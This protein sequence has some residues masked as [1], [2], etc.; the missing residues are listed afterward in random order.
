MRKIQNLFLTLFIIAV[1]QSCT[2]NKKAKNSSDGQDNQEINNENSADD[3]NNRGLKSNKKQVGENTTPI[4]ND[5]DA[6]IQDAEN[7]GLSKDFSIKG[8]IT[9]GHRATITLDKIG[10]GLKDYKPLFNQIINEDGEFGF[11]LTAPEPGLYQLRLPSGMI[12]LVVNGGEDIIVHSNIDQPWNYE[13]MNSPQSK[14]LL[15]F[16]LI[17]EDAN[18]KKA[19]QREKLNNLRNKVSAREFINYNDNLYP[20]EIQK[21]EDF[22]QKQIMDFVNTHKK[23]FVGLLAA[24]YINVTE[25]TKYIENY[26][27]EARPYFGTHPFFSGIATKVQPL[28]NLMPGKKAPEIILDNTDGKQFR[29]SQLQGKFV[30]IDFWASWCQPCRNSNP[31]MK[32]IYEKYKSKNFEIFA[33]SLDNVKNEWVRAINQDELP[34]IHVSDLMGYNSDIAQTYAISAIPTTYLLDREGNV[35]AKN[36]NPSQL[37]KKLKELTSSA[38]KKN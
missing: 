4:S 38:V 7:G 15:N 20:I 18:E 26:L 2:E 21:I 34:W 29:L 1:L 3:S 16:Y 24:N 10:V 19:V 33:V 14:D 37:D 11:N 8:T 9:G 32:E 23:E 30:L 22:K 12:H 6:Y 28:I 17:L 31:K 27:T 36:L 5:A 13:V 35:V 25:N